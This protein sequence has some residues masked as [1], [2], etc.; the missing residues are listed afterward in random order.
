M[1][2]FVACKKSYLLTDFMYFKFVAFNLK[3]FHGSSNCELLT[4]SNVP[5]E[6]YRNV[7][8]PSP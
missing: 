5:Y 2:L 6:I 7:R 3:V 4:Q 1:L 8:C